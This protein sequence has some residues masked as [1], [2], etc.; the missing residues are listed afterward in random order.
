M[1]DGRCAS[2]RRKIE[3]AHGQDGMDTEYGLPGLAAVEDELQRAA[4][5]EH[6]THQ[7]SLKIIAIMAY[8]EGKKKQKLKQS[9]F[10]YLNSIKN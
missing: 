8:A 1:P 3:N 10:A 7:Y 6:W 4:K 9:L 5:M 2:S